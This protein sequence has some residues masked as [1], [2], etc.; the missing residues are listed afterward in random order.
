MMRS[1]FPGYIEPKFNGAASKKKPLKRPSPISI[2]FSE[3]QLAALESH[4]NGQALGPYIKDYVLRHHSIEVKPRRRGPIKDYDALA[5]LLRGLGKS[6]LRTYLCA[7]Y[8][9]ANEGQLVADAETIDHLKQACED[10]TAMRRDLVAALG[11]REGRS[12]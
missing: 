7:L 10:I 6:E 1:S 3:A 5:R 11:P 2:R 8:E 9:L 12:K 4:T